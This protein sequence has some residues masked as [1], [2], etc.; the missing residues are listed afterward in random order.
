MKNINLNKRK[1]TLRGIDFIKT[2]FH[3]ISY[4]L[5][6]HKV[7]FKTNNSVRKNNISLINK[8]DNFFTGIKKIRIEQKKTGYK[9]ME[10]FKDFCVNYIV[11]FF[12]VLFL[13]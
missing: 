6:S 2:K 5:I 8:K 7:N 3:K 11:L 4:S 1:P 9:K 10:G 13:G 12:P